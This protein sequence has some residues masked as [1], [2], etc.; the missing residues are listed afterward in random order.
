MH[1]VVVNEGM[2]YPPTAGNRIRTLNLMLRLARKHRITYLCRGNGNTDSTRE[3]TRYLSDHG[4]E[5]L[6]VDDPP[7]RKSGPLFYGRLAA[8]LISPSPYAVSSHNSAAVRSAIRSFASRNAVDL[9][10][11]EWLAYADVLQDWPNTPTILM[12]HNVESVIWQRYHDVETNLVR[13]WYIRRQQRKFERTEARLFAGA[14]RTVVVSSNDADLARRQFRARNISVVENGIDTA[15]FAKATGSRDTNRILFLGSLDWRPNLDAVR[16]LL[17]HIFPRVVAAFPKA[18][19]SIVGRQPPEW[20]KRRI[21]NT[22][23]VE[24]HANV[25]DVRPFLAESGV[26][27]VPLRI[28]G[29]SRLKIL[30]AMACGLPVVSTT[31]G[32][33]GLE[34]SPETEITVADSCEQ[35]AAALLRCLRD[36]ACAAKMAC[37]ARETVLHRHDWDLLAEKLETIWFEAVDTA[38]AEVS[39]LAAACP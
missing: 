20:L 31:V 25:E 5:S 1:V 10:Q 29:G 33:E 19:L 39:S 28:G 2:V 37:Q 38:S 26:M 15:F 11:F 36:P 8:N 4:I 34:L 12:A 35:I 9:W 14:T 32:C 6:E 27:V 23:H 3:A 13:K 17:D 21:K 7:A 30:E 16:Q 18:Q 24:L 22:A